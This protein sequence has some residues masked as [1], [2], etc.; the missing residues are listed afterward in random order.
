MKDKSKFKK[1]FQEHWESFKRNNPAYDDEYYEESVQK[2][3][4]CGDEGNGYT[5]FRCTSCGLDMKRIAFTCKSG[6]CLSCGKLYSDRVVAQ[7]SKMLHPGVV[8]RHVVLTVPEQLR[9]IFYKS[10]KKGSLYSAL[11]RIGYQCL[12]D[13]V[14]AGTKKKLLKV[15][16]IVVIH[17]HGRPGSYNPHVHVIMT[18]GGI[19][20]ETEKWVNLG[21]FPYEILHKKWQYHLLTMMKNMFGED[22]KGQIDA[23]WKQYPKGFVGHVSKGEAPKHS[24]GLAKYLAKYVASPPI[25]LKRIIRYNGIDVTYWYKDHKT[26]QRK[27]ETIAVE[28]FIGRMVQHI[29]PKGFQRIRYYG[30]QATKTFTRW[31]G[32]IKEG[33]RKIGKVVKDTYQ[34][35]RLTN[36]RARHLESMGKDPLSCCRCGKDMELW[37]IWHPKYGLLYD[38]ESMGSTC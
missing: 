29:L 25:S 23:L 21:Y 13:V 2:M 32:A 19:D 20:T 36:Y 34:V 4:S 27:T 30:L 17:T 9:A 3:L 14:S 33:L 18:D 26:K 38:L 28:K 16:A 10:R 31:C 37:R 12:E 5:E 24:K 35:I 11:I 7:V 15:G 6:F 8:Y 22:I 1:I